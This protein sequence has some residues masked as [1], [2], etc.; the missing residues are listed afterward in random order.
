MEEIH[1]EQLSSLKTIVEGLLS[2]QVANVWNV[3]G[4]LN[5]LHTILQ[6][7]L[8]H[9][10][11]IFKDNGEEDCW[12]FVEGLS[13]LQPNLASSPTPISASSSPMHQHTDPAMVWLHNSLETHTLSEKLSWL[14]SDSSH[15]SAYY[16]DQA[17]LCQRDYAEATLVCLKAVEQNRLSLLSDIPTHLYYTRI[18]GKM[19]RR[20]SSLPE[21]LKPPKP[22]CPVTVTKQNTSPT[23]SWGS[24]P[25][26]AQAVHPAPP[27]SSTVPP[28]PAFKKVPKRIAAMSES[29]GESVIS[30][31]SRIKKKSFIEDG[32]GRSILP[33]RT[34]YF[35]RPR[36]GQSLTSFLRS[37][38]FA[39][40]ELDRENAHFS[41]SEAIIAAIEQVKWE[42][43]VE[44]ESDEEIRD[45]KEKLRE[46][47]RKREVEKRVW[48]VSDSGC[49]E[50]SPS[51]KTSASGGSTDSLSTDVETDPE[52]KEELVS[53]E[54]TNSA[55]GVALSL[56]KEF[57]GRHLPK[58]S[59][60]D[61]LVSEKDAP[62]QLLPLPESMAA[63]SPDDDM[64][65]ATELRGTQLWAPPRP[66]V[67]FTVHPPQRRAVV[68]ARQKFRCAGCGMKIAEEYMGRL[69]Y[70]EYLG[71]YF[72]TGCHSGNTSIIPGRILAKWDFTK[73][74]VSNFSSKLL[75]GMYSDPL[76]CPA[77]V[78]ANLYR[79][80]KLLERTKLLRLRLTY[81]KEFLMTCRFAKNEQN[82]LKKEPD[83]MLEMTEIYSL[84]DLC[85]LKAGKLSER[86][87]HL[88]ALCLN[89]ISNCALCQGR[90]FM[91]E[92]CRSPQVIYPWELGKV[93]R[94]IKCGSCRH[95]SCITSQ[96][97][98]CERQAKR[99]SAG[100]T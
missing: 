96:C 4:G 98:R 11:K 61:W 40:A 70:C 63:T 56:L 17:F 37:R 95:A 97:P 8:K 83:Y 1:R 38:V 32:G 90:G 69:R 72:C 34:G 78:N 21:T 73:Y 35:P 62:Q 15:L 25:V 60:I 86:L 12:K 68:M 5:R 16:T 28:S 41:V 79:R 99:L 27:S 19:H 6:R 13:W 55:E 58:A 10:F 81:L 65:D 44:E 94:C 57:S 49:G 50:T 42:V 51:P 43:T 29:S 93:I 33:M 20:C 47:R 80:V 76:F 14:I 3:Y 59:E 100:T 22:V 23:A 2:C 31:K 54:N 82:E 46:R 77:D 64:R 91:C 48:P 71:R 18:P 85:S 45:L 30:Y 67:I 53:P 84:E 26:L 24:L 88:A 39:S 74:P 89:H 92:I 36:R 9:E 52:N 66:Q 75:E 87:A 7:I